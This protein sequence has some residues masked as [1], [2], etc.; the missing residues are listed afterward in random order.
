[1]KKRIDIE[2]WKRKNQYLFF[3]QFEEP[4]YGVC[5]TIDCTTAY[6]KAKELNCSFSLY[7]LH[8]SLIAVN[9]I[10]NFRYGIEDGEAYLYDRVDVSTTVDRP[11]GTFGMSDSIA[12]H[13]DFKIFEAAALDEMERVRESNHLSPVCGNNVVHYSAVPWIDFTSLSH[14]RKFSREDSSP[15]I[16]F[17]KMTENEGVRTMPVSIHVHHALVDGSHLGK[18]IERFQE[19]MN[20]L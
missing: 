3:K 11:D 15:K 17:G 20:K 12:Y 10:E 1:M 14:A 16:S 4:F 19:L 13:P 5:V 2:T 18:F 8:C 9:D 7:Y 6:K